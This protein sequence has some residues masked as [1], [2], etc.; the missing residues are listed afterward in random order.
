MPW[1]VLPGLT[2]DRWQ[3]AQGPLRASSQSWQDV[4]AE[5]L[6]PHIRP[7][8]HRV[9]LTAALRRK[10]HRQC[11]AQSG[12]K[13]G[14]SAPLGG[15]GWGVKGWCWSGWRRPTPWRVAPNGN[16]QQRVCHD[17]GGAAAARPTGRPSLCEESQA[18][19]TRCARRL[20][21]K[22]KDSRGRW[23]FVRRFGGL[24]LA[25]RLN[26]KDGMILTVGQPA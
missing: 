26:P 19:R 15:I 10:A 11:S 21:A 6:H 3:Q 5:T 18:A 2:R 7:F 25:C 23:V 16:R 8:G 12:G 22:T 17:P 14:G 1:T 4:Q 9:T 13:P 20:R 24:G